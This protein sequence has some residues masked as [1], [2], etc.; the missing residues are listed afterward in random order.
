MKISS[1]LGILIA[2]TS[3]PL[4]AQ[5]QTE[6]GKLTEVVVTA[7][8]K[9]ESLQKAAVAVTALSGADIAS[10]GIKD[11]I[12]IRSSL[13]GVD[14][15]VANT[16]VMVVR[17]VGT[18]NNQ[19][20]VDSAVAY[21]VDGTYLSHHPA[22]MPILFD[23]QRVEAVRGPQGTL[24]GRNSNGG[25][26][27][28]Q[29]NAPVLDKFQAS[30]AA[31]AGNYSAIGSQLMLNAPLGS[32]SA[33][34]F[35]FA[36]D[37]HDP[38]F[39]D[40]SQGAD[41]YAGRVRW[42]YQPSETFDFTAT[43]DY[44]KKRHQ[45]QGSSYCPPNSAYAACATVP[46]DPYAG[47][48][49]DQSRAHF[50]IKNA[51]AYAEMNWHTDAGVLTSITSY[52]DY[53][54]DNTWV[55]DFVEYTP[56]N[57]N[58]FFTQEIRFGAPSHDPQ[59]LDW[60]AG[61]FYS[62]ESLTAVEAYDFFGVPSLRFRWTDAS[63]KSQAI[64]GQVTYPVSSTLRLIGGLR[65]T[66][67]RKDQF[68]SA[69]TFDA[70]G[71]IPTTVATGGA[72][73]EERVTW[74]A[75]I[76]YDAA[77][78]VLLYASASNGFKSGGVNQ[79]PPGL[80]LTAVYNPEKILAY[81]AGMKS[82]FLNQ[83][84][85]FNTEAFYYDYKGYQQYSQE[86]DPTGHFPAVFFITVDS[87]KATFYGAEAEA[88]MLIGSGGQLNLGVTGLHARFNQFVVGSI[89]N[90]GHEVQGAPDYT[91]NAGYQH[92]FDLASGAQLRGRV[93]SSYVDG[94]YAANNNARGSFQSAYTRTDID[95][96]FVSAN[97]EWTITAF[98]RNLEDEAVLAS[99]ADP[100]SRG[101][102]IGF[103]EAPRTYGIT[104]TWALP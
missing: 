50:N 43:V 22:L 25:A 42:L 3:A 78:D 79:V 17:G 84:F 82:R 75:G 34:R 95:A 7:Q 24:Y 65:Y 36:N 68:G 8:K 61:A 67:E 53:K 97:H 13:P 52:R 40:G 51:G 46:D 54:I 2:C 4:F 76:D 14:F 15:Q 10:T 81:Q 80:G 94:H 12:E 59:S 64:F 48:G 23:L 92:T 103:L 83:R 16:P 49:G 29:T 33:L 6:E 11:P 100:I 93:S 47:Y 56:D 86:A 19:P 66:D 30:A 60:V 89:N 91:L 37:K 57:S 99:Y 1:S 32:T 39:N 104:V 26:L 20:G 38:Y 55:W 35:A 45:G 28:I 73:K 71:T 87:Q 69:T 102:D 90:T 98:V 63:S 5:E 58:H 21:T 88:T 85:Q 44:A 96:S 9:E 70:T 62:H 18:Y 27:N 31:T 74:K 72:N 77:E 41:N 101:G